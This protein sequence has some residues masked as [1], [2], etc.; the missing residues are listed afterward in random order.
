MF[1]NF[2]NFHEKIEIILEII[3]NKDHAIKMVKIFY[4]NK[5]AINYIT[6]FQKYIFFTKFNQV[7]L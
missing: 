3:H 5:S 4:Q 1:S 2:N 6:F 7:I